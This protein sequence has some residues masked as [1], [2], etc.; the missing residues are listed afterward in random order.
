[1]AE[2]LAGHPVT[3]TM[4]ADLPPVEVDPVFIDQVLTNLLENAARYAP[5][6][7]PIRVRAEQVSERTIRLTVDDGGP[8][9]PPAALAGLFE[10]FRG[11]GP[12]KDLTRGGIGLAVV[13]GFV[14][15]M[16][17]ASRRNWDLGAWRST[18]TCALLHSRGSPGGDA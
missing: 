13:R 10:K 2:L 6:D 11:P 17:G 3:V 7:A 12:A 9:V 15:A 5:L 4:R 18:S 1:M 8:G 16:G 14:E